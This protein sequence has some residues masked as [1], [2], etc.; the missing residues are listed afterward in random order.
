MSNAERSL[1][2]LVIIFFIFL[3]K[4]VYHLLFNYLEFNTIK[5]INIYNNFHN[6]NKI[7]KKKITAPDSFNYS[8]F[9]KNTSIRSIFY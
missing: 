4:A 7:F 3:L 5:K 6:F 9:I 2:G 1:Y 8:Q